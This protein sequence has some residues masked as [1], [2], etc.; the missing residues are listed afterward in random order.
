MILP[1]A[2]GPPQNRSS[3][4]L[5]TLAITAYSLLLVPKAAAIEDCHALTNI[6]DYKI[7]VDE[8]SLPPPAATGSPAATSKTSSSAVLRLTAVLQTQVEEITVEEGGAII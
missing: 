2:T 3:M 7:A 8:V 5:L 4:V 1:K 6:P